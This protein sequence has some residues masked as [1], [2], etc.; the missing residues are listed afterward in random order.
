MQTQDRVENSGFSSSWPSRMRP[1][2]LKARNTAKARKKAVEMT[3]LQPKTR[4]I[5]ASTAPAVAVRLSGPATPQITK[6]RAMAM[7]GQ[8]TPPSNPLSG[9][10]CMKSSH[11]NES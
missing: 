3:K 8:N 7:A 11:F 2:R 1:K 10:S 5:Q 4:M 9:V 6:P